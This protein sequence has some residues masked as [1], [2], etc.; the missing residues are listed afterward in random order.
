MEITVHISLSIFK[1]LLMKSSDIL[2]NILIAILKKSEIANFDLCYLRSFTSLFQYWSLD[3]M[4][5]NL[6][7]HFI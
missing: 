4:L 7:C 2:D 5:F 3:T 1:V 6:K